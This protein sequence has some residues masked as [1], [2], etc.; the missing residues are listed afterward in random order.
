MRTPLRM[1]LS[2]LLVAVL[3]LSLSAMAYPGKADDKKAD[4]KATQP[5][6]KST[7]P[8]LTRE[9]M[10]NFLLNAE[11]VSAKQSS[12]GI[13]S[14]W[15][16]TLSDGTLTHDAS[17]QAV[18]EHTAMK[19]LA[20]GRT[21]MNFV[22]SWKYNLAGSILAEMLGLDD[23]IPVYVERKWKGKTGSL[24]WWMPVQMDDAQRMKEHIQPPDADAWNHQ[25]YRLRVF[26]QLIYDTDPNL[27]N[28]LISPDWKLF[29]VDF[30]RAFRTYKSLQSEKDL[31]L[32]DRQ[33]LEKLKALNKEQ[34]AAAT[35]RYLTK[36]EVEGVMARRDKIVEH[37]Q[38]LI[39]QNG[40]NAVLY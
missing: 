38:K 14:P 33:L 2:S 34:F 1:F 24:S 7:S 10:R 23:V 37:F 39:S 29:R 36:S 15:R 4:E 16:L 19:E 35:K 13:T 26:D 3:L 12:K 9:Q 21:E 31:Q 5:E 27:T 6:N 32:C 8:T 40:E 30:S 22:D 11:V 17:F 18:D 20:S 25:M 28:I